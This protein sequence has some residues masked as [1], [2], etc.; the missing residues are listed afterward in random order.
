MPPQIRLRQTI[1]S[2]CRAEF[3]SFYLTLISLS[4][5]EILLGV[6]I[7]QNWHVRNFK[8]SDCGMWGVQAFYFHTHY[9]PRFL[10]HKIFVKI[11]VAPPWGAQGAK[12]PLF[13]ISKTVRDFFKIPKPC[14]R[15]PK[16]ATFC[17]WDCIPL[18][19]AKPPKFELNVDF[20]RQNFLG[21]NI[22]KFPSTIF[23]KIT[24]FTEGSVVVQI[25]KYL[26]AF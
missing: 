20:G 16:T 6:K 7:G 14:N 9:V 25:T 21:A 15:A 26:L 12:N 10:V 22:S 8:N 13:K 18:T 4:V 23:L 1:C 5:P 17:N 11:G 19:P 24:H 2:L 3:N